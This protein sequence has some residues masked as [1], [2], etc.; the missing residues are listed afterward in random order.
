MSAA[1]LARTGLPRALARRAVL[2]RNKATSAD[3]YAYVPGGPIYKGTVN[4]PTQFPTPSRS[5]GSYHWSFERLLSAGLLPLTGAAF[6]TSAS[7]YPML[8]GLLGVAL[9][10]HSHIGFDA[11]IVD[12]IHV[13]KFPV[14]GRIA[15]WGLRSAT[16]GV[17][18]GIYQFNTNDIGLTELIS[19]VWTA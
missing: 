3:P 12:Y 6:A 11:L 15:T 5:H 10:M 13:R 18:V 1:L 17:L 14:L 7:A 8:D 16:V 9:V 2:V 19:K 4:D